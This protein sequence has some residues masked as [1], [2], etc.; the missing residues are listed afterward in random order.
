MNPIILALDFNSVSTAQQM[1]SRIRPY[2]GMIKI[3]LEL[4]TAHGKEALALGQE[5]H[6]PIF[7]DL[8]L[9]DIPHTVHRT[10]SVLCEML[11]PISGQHFVS[12]HTFGGIEMCK[13]A[14]LTSQNSNVEIVGI[15][16]LSSLDTSDL[17]SFGFSDRRVGPKTIELAGL[18]LNLREDDMGLRTFVCAPPQLKLMRQYFGKELTLISPGIRADNST[19]D[20]KRSASAAFALKNGADWLVIGR[21]ITQAP[22]PI[23]AAQYYQNQVEKYR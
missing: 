17:E 7:L 1:L 21:P 19:D 13:E 11:A 9:H 2:I 6:I 16:L 15:T 18:S 22:D 8:K 23:E 5:F 10:I 3:G 14:Y 12:I 4:F 20:H